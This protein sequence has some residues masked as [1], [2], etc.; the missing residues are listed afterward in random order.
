MNLHLPAHY[1][2][3]RG[4]ALALGFGLFLLTAIVDLTTTAE[5][6]LSPFYIGIIL[7]VSWNVGPRYGCGFATLATMTEIVTGFYSGFPFS[8]P[9]YFYINIA[10]R[11]VSY[12]IVAMLTGQLRRIYQ[13]EHTAARIDFLTG[14]SNRKAFYEALAGDI[15][16]LERGGEA[17]SLA[18]FDCD[19]FKR[20]NDQHGHHRGDEILRIVADTLRARVRHTDVIARLGGDEF[21]VLL[22]AADEAQATRTAETL[23]RL[24]DERMQ[25]ERCP[26]SFSIGVCTFTHPPASVDAAIKVCDT[27]MYRV[28]TGGG[29]RV[30]HA[31]VTEATAT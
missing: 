3:A 1:R 23:K 28:K 29:N 20:V 25:A 17:L 8:S 13:Q 11:Y 27:L 19:G 24:L 12:V 26:V 10:N 6:T 16:R 7:L 18:Y 9:V 31:S 4:P 21:A 14:V 30:A 2:L 15:A 5:L 22:P